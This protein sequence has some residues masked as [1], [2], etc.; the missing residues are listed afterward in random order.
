MS[1]DLPRWY[2][3]HPAI[4]DIHKTYLE[5]ADE[6]PFFKGPIPKRT[7][8]PK[9]KW[10]DFLGV[11]V[12]S[13]IGVPAGPL[14]TAPW[15]DLAAKLGF[16][17]VTY[18]TIRSHRSPSHPLPNM[19]FVSLHGKVLHHPPRH[20]EDLAVTNSFGN[21][22]RGPEFLMEDLPKANASLHEGQV[23]VVSVFG[24]KRSDCTLLEDFVQ[25]ALLAKNAGAKIIEANFSCPNVDK[26]EGCMYMSPETVAEIGSAIV[27]AIAPVPLIIKAGI[28]S[29]QQQ[30]RDVLR[31]AAKAGIRSISGINTVSMEVVDAHGNPALGPSR[32]TSGVCGGPIR[33]VA[34]EFV[35]Q[36]AEINRQDKL[37]LTLIGVGGITLPEHFDQFLDAGADFA[38]SATGMMWDP[39][40]AARYHEMKQREKK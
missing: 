5:N 22:S 34:L 12:A 24:T 33:K 29:S 23:M 18:K 39:Y 10:I 37:D 1:S 36:A 27:K 38:Q 7:F 40:L 4:Y 6:G 16:D 31:A 30:M 9:E 35:G 14:L 20:I 19:V 17:I 28:F 11:K 13:R 8:P 32:L 25:A 21:P 2:P 3:D 26:S 15:I